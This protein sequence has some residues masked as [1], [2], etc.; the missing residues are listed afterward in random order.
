[1]VAIGLPRPAVGTK[2]RNL[3]LPATTKQRNFFGMIAPPDD[4][5]AAAPRRPLWTPDKVERL[6]ALWNERLSSARIAADLGPGFTR[7]AVVGKLFRLGLKRSDEQRYAAQ[8][9]GARQSHRR[10]SAAGW[11]E[12]PPAFPVAPLPPP[13]PCAVVPRQA[14]R[15]EVGAHAC[16]WPYGGE[17][18]R[19]C[20][21]RRGSGQAYC[22]GHH[23]V[24]YAGTLP[25][26]TVEEL[27]APPPRRVA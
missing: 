7:N 8:A 20:G 13:R 22:P 2:Y 9:A 18:V 11:P 16:R 24:A 15:E 26:L 27:E 1:M 25:P 3:A 14:R 19:F 12:R 5:F 10:R 4:D 17:E 6:L 23:A 21:R